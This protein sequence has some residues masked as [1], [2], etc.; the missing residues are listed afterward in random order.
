VCHLLQLQGHYIKK[1]MNIQ[2]FLIRV[3]LI[4]YDKM[5]K[6]IFFY[7]FYG[8]VFIMKSLSKIIKKQEHSKVISFYK[9]RVK[10]SFKETASDNL[11]FHSDLM[12]NLDLIE[13]HP[14]LFIN[15]KQSYKI[16]LSFIVE[17]LKKYT[18]FTKEDIN[19]Y[20]KSAYVKGYEVRKEA[21]NRHYEL[22]DF[23]KNRYLPFLEK[24]IYQVKKTIDDLTKNDTE[25]SRETLSN[26]E[27]NEPQK[28]V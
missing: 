11:V 18:N 22:S 9:Q 16:A 15:D 23:T 10:E 24:I 3:N 20:L 5:Q 21:R 25:V 14:S 12:K 6:K 27:Y 7:Y 17:I 19:R 4:K 26:D 13:Y 1:R 28:R 8:M 2:E